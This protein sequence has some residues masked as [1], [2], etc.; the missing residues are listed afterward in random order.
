MLRRLGFGAAAILLTITII[1]FLNAPTR[2]ADPSPLYASYAERFQWSGGMEIDWVAPSELLNLAEF[3]DAI[4]H[5][6]VIQS[7]ERS[8]W[9]YNGCRLFEVKVHSY[10]K[11]P[12]YPAA[13][14]ILIS[15]VVGESGNPVIQP[16]DECVFFLTLYY[17]KLGSGA[18]YSLGGDFTRYIVYGER[19]YSVASLNPEN[20]SS[21]S[22]VRG[23]RLT[24]FLARVADLVK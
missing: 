1:T 23:E 4:V 14:T 18:V 9:L 19:M 5:G 12:E 20:V 17:Q 22:P 13:K 7:V 8:T 16:G 3:S 10:L 15:Q 2:D 6:T 21:G 11:A 24:S